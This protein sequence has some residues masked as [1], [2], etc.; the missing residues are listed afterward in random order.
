MKSTKKH[1]LLEANERIINAEC[2]ESKD[3]EIIYKGRNITNKTLA[4]IIYG[5]L[6]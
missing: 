3:L 2:E 6:K 5:D 1:F 4:I